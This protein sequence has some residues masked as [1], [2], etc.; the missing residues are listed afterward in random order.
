M[1]LVHVY[2]HIHIIWSFSKALCVLTLM[3]KQSWLGL[4]PQSPPFTIIYCPRVTKYYVQQPKTWSRRVTEMRLRHIHMHIHTWSKF[5]KDLLCVWHWCGHNFDWIYSFNHGTLLSFDAQSYPESNSN[6]LVK[7][8]ECIVV[9]HPYAHQNHMEVSQRP[10]M[11]L[12]FLMC[13]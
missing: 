13:I 11:C 10:C 8:S 6:S 3:W 2:M 5:V 9:R 1:W 7:E 12:T 4:L